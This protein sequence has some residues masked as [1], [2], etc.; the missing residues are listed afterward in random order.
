MI[1]LV[2]LFTI[3]TLLSLINYMGRATKGLKRYKVAI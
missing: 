1:F 2:F 3:K